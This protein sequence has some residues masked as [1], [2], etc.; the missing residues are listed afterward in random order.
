MAGR[1]TRITLE[2]RNL[3][4]LPRNVEA[5]DAA[6]EQQLDVVDELRE[7]IRATLLTS[8]TDIEIFRSVY[9]F[10][11]AL[12]ETLVAVS[13]ALQRD[14][15]ALKV[16]LHLLSSQRDTLELGEFV[17]VGDLW[18][19]VS[20][21]DEP[22][23]SDLKKAFGRAKKLYNEKLEPM[24]LEEHAITDET[25]ADAPSRTNMAADA[26]ILKTLLLASLVERVAAFT[27]LSVCRL[28]A[29]NW[30]SVK[31]QSWTRNAGARE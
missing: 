7:E 31:A 9:P 10:S 17:P 25:P 22:F 6:T 30:G 11:P 29:L 14:R 28:V 12:V 3:P 26:R 20:S 5:K 4:L 13:E 19:V 21:S 23:S 2:D 8:D 1:F 24:L 16:M 27:D 18:D 15:T